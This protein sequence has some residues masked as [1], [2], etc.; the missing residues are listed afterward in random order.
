MEM[1]TSLDL[2][3]LDYLGAADPEVAHRRIADARRRAPI[4]RGPFGLEL[5]GHEVVHTALA[6]PRFRAPTGLGVPYPRLRAILDKTYTPHA[7]DR[8]RAAVSDIVGRLIDPLADTGRCDVVA[9]VAAPHAVHAVCAALGVKRADWDRL[10]RWADDVTDLEALYHYVDV[11]IAQRCAHLSDDL[12]SDLII[13]DID[14]DGLTT[15]ELRRLV[16]TLLTSEA[17]R[18]R[19]QLA[20]SVE[21][22]CDQPEQWALLAENAD[23]APRAVE[24][25]MR[26]SPVV[27]SV[28][29]VAAE[30]VDLD[31]IHIP[32]DTVV[33]VNIAA[34]Q[35]DPDAYADPER[36]DITRV[37]PPS[38]PDPGRTALAEALRVMAQRM[39]AIRRT[40]TAPW[41][42]IFGI[43]G[44]TALHV[45][46]GTVR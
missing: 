7:A 11:M 36:L 38:T 17:N 19:S 22:L 30:D 27:F 24:E 28:L 37:L 31:G 25:T 21:A 16:A 43:S 4:A 6:D 2:P 45:E 46:F 23:L 15:D 13:A 44:P 32:A 8:L 42:P 41:K 40:A 14:H 10:A 34:A 5:I 18:M 33:T 39:P 3:T 35:R 12:L 1:T 26:H 29:R 20:A 9:D